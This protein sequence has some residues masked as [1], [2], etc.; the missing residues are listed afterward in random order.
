[1]PESDH[2]DYETRGIQINFRNHGLAQRFSMSGT[3][4]L[5]S[6]SLPRGQSAGLS[7]T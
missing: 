7:A 5:E 3:M 1:M 4:V 6:G 2:R